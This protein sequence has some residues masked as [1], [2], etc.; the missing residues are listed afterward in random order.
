MSS[1]TG[2]FGQ[3]STLLQGFGQG[4]DSVPG[5]KDYTHASKTFLPNGY[6]LTPRLKFLYHV[7]FN[8]NTGQIPQLQAAYGSGTVET[9]GLMVKSIDLPKFKI[10]TAVMNQYNR[11]RLIQSKVRYEASK[12]SFHDDQSD[13]IRNMWY[14]YFTY[15]YKDA[16]QQYQNTPNRPSNQ[17]G[18]LGQVMGL[19]NGFNYNDSVYNQ[20]LQTADWGYVGETY[21]NGTNNLFA[22]AGKPPFFR[23]ITIYGMSQKKYAAWVLINPIITNWNHDT[24]DYSQG[25]ETMKNDVTIEYETVKY[26]KG[27]IGS[28]HPSNVVS[29]FADPAHYDTTPSGITRPGGSSYVFGQGGMVRAVNG[30]VQDLQGPTSGQGGLQNVIGA[31]Q[32]AATVY[33]TFSN[34]DPYSIVQPALQQSA[35]TQALQSLPNAVNA[36]V[37]SVNGFLFPVASNAVLADAGITNNELETL[38][39]EATNNIANG[40]PGV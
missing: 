21:S 24:Y 25:G 13:L 3:G 36:A 4:I 6:Q 35:I 15:Y 7:Y 30:S 26:M 40:I 27:N 19:F 39:T 1:G 12:I 9:I 10:D 5:V 29:G 2:Y 17:S 22:P 31:V 38:S 20:I 16:T 11:K 28:E 33:N 34:T 32:T 23:D 14:N 8:I 37:N 18:T